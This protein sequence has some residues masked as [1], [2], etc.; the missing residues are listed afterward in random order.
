MTALLTD[1]DYALIRNYLR[2]TAGLEF[3][4]SRRVSLAGV[5][6]ERLPKSG[7]A[8]MASYV[9]YI[10]RPDG[11]AERQLLLDDVTIQETHFHR[12]R[13]QIDALRDHL[14]PELLAAAAESGR[15]L[16][17]W[18]AGCSTGEEVYTLAMLALEARERLTSG[19]L[20]PIRVVGTDV[21]SA[22]LEVARAARYGGRTI[23]L[24]EPGAVARWLQPEAGGGFV[25]RD[26]VRRLVEFAHHNL[27][28]ELPPFPDGAVNLVVCRNVTIYFSRATTKALVQRFRA[29]LGAAGWLLL[30]PAETL[31]QVSD[32]FS[33]VGVGDAFAYRPAVVAPSVSPSATPSSA[34]SPRVSRGTAHPAG[35]P[36]PRPVPPVAIGPKAQ[37]SGAGTTAV[38]RPGED[39]LSSAR[40]AMDLTKYAEAA[41]LATAAAQEDPLLTEAYV[42][43]GH[44]YA[45]L[46]RDAEA[47]GPLGR[48]VYL[49]SR[50]G[51]AWFLLAGSLG[52]TGDRA[53]AARAYRA[54]AVALPSAPPQA[55]LGLLD[56]TPVEQLVQ[57]C[58]RLADDLEELDTIRR[59]A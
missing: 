12:A 48:A 6:A 41:A 24:A 31:W 8:D 20:P 29:V 49:D 22:A 54:A 58:H 11:A 2:G 13:P 33:L 14:L 7:Q 50:A 40:T 18:S 15:G 38:V 59:G 17:I 23:D 51:H 30:G 34:L 36:S 16:T 37:R 46:G 56:G 35:R 43:A 25:V 3:D 10:D 21:S 42:V 9:R 53:A 39:L 28:T 32:A 19:A 26:E 1:A 4:V 57:L 44:A 47:L 52:R 5:M 45:T 27:V 55:V